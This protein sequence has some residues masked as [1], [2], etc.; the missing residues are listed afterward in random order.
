MD[1]N[2]GRRYESVEAARA[3]GVAEGDLY[4]IDPKTDPWA[5][6]RADTSITVQGRGERARRLRQLAKVSR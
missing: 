4:K 6:E 2:T 5:K 3:A 1:L